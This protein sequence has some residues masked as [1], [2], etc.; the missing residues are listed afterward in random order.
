MITATVVISIVLL[1]QPL[2]PDMPDHGQVCLELFVCE[3]V[4]LEQF[5]LLLDLK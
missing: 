1:L 5:V 3:P 4:K 2:H